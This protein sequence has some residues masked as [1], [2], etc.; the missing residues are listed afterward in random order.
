[1]AGNS[2]SGR[3]IAK[4]FRSDRRVM[5]ERR[6]S[7]I[8]EERRSAKSLSSA[9]AGTPNVIVRSPGSSA[10]RV[11]RVPARAALPPCA[12][13]DDARRARACSGGCRQRV[14]AANGSSP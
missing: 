8:T 6:R 13:N 11:R 14:R 10:V 9:A 7:V 4:H 3:E 12:A 5:R 1:V 2:R